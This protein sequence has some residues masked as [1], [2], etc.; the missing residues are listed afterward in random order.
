MILHLVSPIFFSFAKNLSMT[1]RSPTAS[2][3]APSAWRSRPQASGQHFLSGTLGSGQDRAIG[4]SPNLQGWAAPLSP[5]PPTWLSPSPHALS[6][7]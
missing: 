5:A 4:R 7:D 3:W 6:P 1:Q 2:A